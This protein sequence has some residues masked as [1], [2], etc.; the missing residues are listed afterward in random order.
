M[1]SRDGGRT[2]TSAYTAH[3]ELMGALQLVSFT[4]AKLGVAI[5]EESPTRSSLVVTDDG[6]RTWRRIAL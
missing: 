2:W 5:N 6:G 1:T 4:S 3:S